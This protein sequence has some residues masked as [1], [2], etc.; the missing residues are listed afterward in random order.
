MLIRTPADLGAVIRDRRKR[1]K[2]DQLT[3]AKRIGVSR[4]WVIDIEH[5]HPRAELA[6]VLRALDALGIP[7]DA[8]DETT[9]SR[10]SAK[11]AVDINAI[12]TKA[13]KGKA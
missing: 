4:Q 13:K 1:L 3:L 8:S 5:G 11:S 10:G 7:L 9:T 2:L 12:L 6:L